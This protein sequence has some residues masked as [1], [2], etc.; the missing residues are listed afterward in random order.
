[1]VANLKEDVLYRAVGINAFPIKVNINLKDYETLLLTSD[2]GSGIIS[3]E[4][5]SGK[6]YYT[7][8]LMMAGTEITSGYI[9]T[10]SAEDTG[11][12]IDKYIGEVSPTYFLIKGIKK[13]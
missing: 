11:F 3:R 9:V 6:F 2:R 5:N 12:T 10:F 8:I 7:R 4:A 13:I 1:M